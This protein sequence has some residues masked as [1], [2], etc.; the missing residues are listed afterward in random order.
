MTEFK[1]DV[2]PDCSAFCR[3]VSMAVTSWSWKLLPDVEAVP[4]A[5]AELELAVAAVVELALPTVEAVELLDCG[6][7]SAENSMAL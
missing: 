4:V 5:L 7:N 6:A 3:A 2:L 1:F